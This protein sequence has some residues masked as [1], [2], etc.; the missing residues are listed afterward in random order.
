MW[1]ID[2]GASDH[3]CNNLCVFANY[4]SVEQEKH[5]VTIP[6]GSK[7]QVE[8]SGTVVL[9]N[10]IALHN[11]LFVPKFNYNLISVSK[12]SVDMNCKIYFTT[13]GCF[14]QEPLMMKPWLLGEKRNGLYIIQEQKGST[15]LPPKTRDSSN[16]SSAT[17]SS[18]SLTNKAKLW[19]LRMGH[20]PIQKLELLIP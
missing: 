5:E 4:N 9:Q 19:H 11:V 18:D 20:M 1:I 10:G 14:V 7:F 15:R 13:N 6:D 16:I 2:S 17:T 12:L 8:I 3:M